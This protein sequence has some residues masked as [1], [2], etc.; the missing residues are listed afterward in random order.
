MPLSH[1][2]TTFSFSLQQTHKAIMQVGLAWVNL[3][4]K[5]KLLDSAE[6]TDT[7]SQLVVPS[8]KVD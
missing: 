7:T 1:Y 5:F 6:I 4:S 2:I 8:G 3:P